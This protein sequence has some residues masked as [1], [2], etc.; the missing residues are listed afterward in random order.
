[1]F[2]IYINN[3]GV[4]NWPMLR[5][6]CKIFCH[7][8]IYYSVRVYPIFIYNKIGMTAPTIS[9]SVLIRVVTLSERDV[10]PSVNEQRRL[11]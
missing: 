1:M 4:R 8:Q 7:Q 5:N 6:Y 10:I 11:R 2:K 9:K 3:C